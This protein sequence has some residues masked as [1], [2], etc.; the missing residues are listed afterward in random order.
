MPTSTVEQSP[1]APPVTRRWARA[2]VLFAAFVC[3]GCGL[4]Y[5]LA[6]VA[7]GSYLIGD[8]IGQASVVLSI[9]VFAMGIGAL[10][11]KPLQRRAEAAFAGVEIALALLGGLSVLLLYGAFAW[12]SLY[13]LALIV[14]AGVLGILIGAEIPLL[15]V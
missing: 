9:M 3:A 13:T 1:S 4:V 10:A 6:L 14:L 7:L 12:L 15:M 8:T 11:A 2:A 5:E